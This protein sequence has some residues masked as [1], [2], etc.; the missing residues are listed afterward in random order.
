MPIV[1]HDFETY[2]YVLRTFKRVQGKLLCIARLFKG[3][4]MKSWPQ[5]NFREKWKFRR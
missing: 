2:W 4:C 1:V 3:K 5:F